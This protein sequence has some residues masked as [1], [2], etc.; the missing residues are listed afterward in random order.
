[1]DSVRSWLDPDEVRR[2][3]QR[4]LVGRGEVL[5]PTTDT[6]FGAAFEGFAVSID[7]AVPTVPRLAEQAVAPPAVVAVAPPAAAPVVAAPAARPPEPP[8]V[9]PTRPVAVPPAVPP[10][11]PP[12]A[13]PPV[14]TRPVVA[15]EPVVPAAPAVVAPVVP[16]EPVEPVAPVA[17]VEPV[18][19]GL[20]VVAPRGPFLQRVERLRDWLGTQFGVRGMFL[21]DREGAV[22]FDDGVS[23]KLQGLA[24]SLAQASRAANGAGS[25]VHV[26]IGADATLE[27]I[28]AV[29]H[30]GPLV[31][32][33]VAPQAIPPKGVALVIDAIQRTAMPPGQGR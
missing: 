6:P 17:P 16:V 18:G 9:E 20:P 26:K 27:V 1:M 11:P 30:Y 12:P 29:T 31:L 13:P 15:V 28:P 33:A 8:P 7:T 32:G 4:L 25:N 22:I 19:V 5:L 14:S 23:E 24:R 2:L 21:L 10:E 3:A